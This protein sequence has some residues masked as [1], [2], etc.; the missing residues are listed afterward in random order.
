MVAFKTTTG[1]SDSGDAP[2][3][4]P[5]AVIRPSGRFTSCGDVCS[6]VAL[7]GVRGAG[8]SG[9]GSESKIWVACSTSPFPERFSDELL[10][11]A[12]SQ[13]RGGQ[14]MNKKTAVWVMLLTSL[15]FA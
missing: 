9:N 8:S 1:K 5:I 3:A 12:N 15:T 7:G 14:Q 6:Y 13:F 4:P 11:K 10:S 2:R